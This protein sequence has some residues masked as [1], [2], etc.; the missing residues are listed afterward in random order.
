MSRPAL[1]SPPRRNSGFTLVEMMI[2]MALGLVVTAAVGYVF[3]AS[4]RNFS[5]S[6]GV[7]SM[8]E[9][10]RSSLLILDT[11]VRQAGYLNTPMSDLDPSTVFVS[12][13]PAVYGG[14]GSPATA[15]SWASLSGL[16]QPSSASSNAYLEVAF[17]GDHSSPTST[18]GIM[19]DCLGRNALSADV[20]VNIFFVAKKSTDAAYSLYCATQGFLKGT[21]TADTT[22]A[23]YEV[24]PLIYGVGAMQLSFGID[25]DGDQ[26]A[27]YYLAASGLTASNWNTVRSVQVWLATQSS[28]VVD[29]VQAASNTAI[30]NTA[31]DTLMTK[32]GRLQRPLAQTI[33]LRNRL[34]K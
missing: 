31:G 23:D 15:F 9:N 13:T 34:I 24:Q 11:M 6:Q 7:S 19:T 4:K 8:Q 17:V 29:G 33:V 26:M 18:D 14:N 22:N 5:Y 16:T 25:S 28:E 3:V 27:N 32:D 21:G 1:P 12:A 20:H 10:A 2:A 30:T